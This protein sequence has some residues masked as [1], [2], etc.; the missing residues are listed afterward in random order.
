[1]LI[2][3]D[4]NRH[5]IWF[6]YHPWSVNSRCS[7]HPHRAGLERG[8]LADGIY[9]W[10]GVCVFRS[11][12]VSLL[13]GLSWTHAGA[14]HKRESP[15]SCPLIDLCFPYALKGASSPL[16]IF[17][18]LLL[19]GLLI[20]LMLFYGISWRKSNKYRAAWDLDRELELK[21]KLKLKLWRQLR[22]G[23]SHAIA[24]CFTCLPLQHLKNFYLYGFQRALK[25]NLN[26]FFFYLD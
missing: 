6:Y 10:R 3:I 23:T 2:T 13:L 20:A 7:S 12:F 4:S 5:L 14:T 24:K 26:H 18:P 19:L 22:L 8:L 1:M 25:F 15:L 9:L 16:A 17:S 11:G 21:L